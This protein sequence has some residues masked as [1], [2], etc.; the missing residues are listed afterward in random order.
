MLHRLV[1][2]T[3]TV[4]LVLVFDPSQK[5]QGLAWLCL[6]RA[7]P[8]HASIAIFHHYRG[9]F[10]VL[11]ANGSHLVVYLVVLALGSSWFK[12]LAHCIMSSFADRYFPVGAV[13]ECAD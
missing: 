10:V 5:F 12:S 2:T 8:L 1:Q 13:G 11:A 3:F 7:D 4:S 6:H 9:K